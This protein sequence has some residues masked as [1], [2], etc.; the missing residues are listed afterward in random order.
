LA[1]LVGDQVEAGRH[2]ARAA[3]LFD[4]AGPT[5]DAGRCRAAIAS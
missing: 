1:R 5:L 3:R 4:D 2:V